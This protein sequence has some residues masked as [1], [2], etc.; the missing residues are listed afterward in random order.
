MTRLILVALLLLAST[1]ALAES[2][3]IQSAKAKLMD[4]PS[5]KGAVV[6]TAE[7]GDEVALVERKDKWVKVS[8]KDKQGW[9]SALLVGTKPPADKVTIIK[10]GEDAN[11]KE[12]VRRRASSSASAAAARGLRQDD[13]ARASDEGQ[14]NYKDLEK[15]ESNKVDAK[16]VDE[17][18]KGAT[19]K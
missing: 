16:A 9:V 12:S 11:Q 13:R 1:P 14:T 2:L 4:N 19:G 10:E 7:K 17:F 8:F 5:F 15:M 6:A 18:S 3:F